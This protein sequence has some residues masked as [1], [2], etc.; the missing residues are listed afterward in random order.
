[1]DNTNACPPASAL[2]NAFE[3]KLITDRTILIPVD[4][5]I[6]CDYITTMKQNDTGI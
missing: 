3:M 2:R 5:E 6:E 1:M 4:T